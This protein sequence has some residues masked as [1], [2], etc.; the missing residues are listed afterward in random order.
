MSR[1]RSAGLYSHPASSREAGGGWCG[2][3]DLSWPEAAS[4]QA[5]C[6]SGPRSG[7]GLARPRQVSCGVQGRAQATGALWPASQGPGRKLGLLGPGQV[8]CGVQGRPPQATEPSG[9]VY[10]HSH[11]FIISTEH[12]L[13]V[14]FL[15]YLSSVCQSLTMWNFFVMEYT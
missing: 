6:E 13:S 1:R 7:A 3:P 15:S 10:A 11:L 2:C 14:I 5:A 8:S 4:Q 12:H 9:E